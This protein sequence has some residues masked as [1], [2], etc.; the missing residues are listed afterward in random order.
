MRIV[1]RRLDY[2]PGLA[3]TIWLLCVLSVMLS[4]GGALQ[5]CAKAPANLP[6]LPPEA[7][8]A[9]KAN[10]AIVAIGTV[11]HVAIELNK[12]LICDSAPA[13]TCHPV[14]S[15]KN[16]GSVI[17]AVRKAL[18]T[19]QQ[20]PNGWKATVSVALD[21]IDAALDEAGKSKLKAYTAAARI[22]VGAL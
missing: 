5:S 4:L 10:E 18:L 17:D 13:A 9:Y 21:Q 6:S 11:Q 15:D 16:T 8:V 14:L 1:S 3:A 12:I 7:Q 2:P 19:I 20:A 22:T